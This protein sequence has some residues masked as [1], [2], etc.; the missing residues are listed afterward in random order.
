[1]MKQNDCAEGQVFPVPLTPLQY[2]FMLAL[3]N[4]LKASPDIGPTYADLMKDL[5]L[6][7]KSGIA[8][9]V[10]ECVERGRIQK[11]SNRDRSLTIL[12][13][14]AE[15]EEAPH[16]LIKSFSDREIICEAQRRGL[17]SFATG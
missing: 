15:G 5:G 10:D 12:H 8:R 1:M 17:I 3:Q 11:S 7:S 14:V 16:D 4:R 6:K 9:L 2:R 13:P